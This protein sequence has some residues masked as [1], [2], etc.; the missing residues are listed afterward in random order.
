MDAFILHADG[1]EALGQELARRI[2]PATSLEAPLAAVSALS[3]GE[4][5][6][7]L[8]IWSARAEAAG[9]GANLADL[10]RR[11]TDRCIVV[12]ADGT[13][14]PAISGSVQVAVLY[15][16]DNDFLAM[17]KV[18]RMRA[19][20]A[21][22]PAPVRSGLRVSSV[23]PGVGVGLA[24]Y[25]GMFV[26]AGAWRSEDITQAMATSKEAPAVDALRS[27]QTAFDAPE[28]AHVAV[29]SAAPN[30]RFVKPQRV[31][32][33]TA[34]D[35]SALPVITGD[36]ADAPAP[37]QAVDDTTDPAPLAPPRATPRTERVPLKPIAPMALTPISPAL[38][39]T[40]AA[41]L[42]L[43]ALDSVSTFADLEKDAF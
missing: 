18:A 42:R 33:T 11:M 41:A 26:A 7:V 25:A 28:T 31:I 10:S 30:A 38:G 24:I 27:F 36:T 35:S 19:R 3:F 16:R 39:D 14:L 9:L 4:H 5:L 6:V 29:A 13:P 17:L 37:L 21:A 32:V 15:G 34:M 40:G 8:A 1:D 23:G 20:P 2:A 22:P 12:R 43:I